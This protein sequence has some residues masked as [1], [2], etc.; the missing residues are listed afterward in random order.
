MDCFN[1]IVVIIHKP[2]LKFC[3]LWNNESSI[4]KIMS[5][6]MALV[7]GLLTTTSFTIDNALLWLV[8]WW[9]SLS[10]RMLKHV[11]WIRLEIASVVKMPELS[12]KS[13]VQYDQFIYRWPRI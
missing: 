11:E 1:Q 9:I 2:S 5:I 4:H 13:A 10:F 7:S 3:I 6:S 12:K 8:I